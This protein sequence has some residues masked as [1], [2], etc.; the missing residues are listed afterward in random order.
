MGGEKAVYGGRE[1]RDGNS[2]KIP[3]RVVNARE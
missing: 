3:F 2:G 1:K